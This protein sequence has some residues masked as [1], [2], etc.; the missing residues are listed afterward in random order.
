LA[1][2][3]RFGSAAEG[4]P[5]EEILAAA[6]TCF[7]YFGFRKTT[8]EDIAKAV[9]I[10]RTSVYRFFQDRDALLSA[11]I[12]SHGAD[13][14][15]ATRTHVE[16]FSTFEDILVEGMLFQIEY[17]RKDLFWQLLVS[18]EYMDIASRLIVS[19][20][21]ALDVTT[22]LWEP[23]IT[24]GQHRGEVKADMDVHAGC[25]WIVLVN[26]TVFGRSDL[27]PEDSE[28]LRSWIRQFAL[29]PFII[30]VS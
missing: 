2:P 25:R 10:S 11:L 24:E 4:G 15:A 9:G 16:Q 13:L 29:P 5:R 22:P 6:K 1:A 3:S 21:A 12:L 23:I 18:P 20:V 17:G 19:S 8:V 7:E 28:G 14:M 27:V 26:V 30:G